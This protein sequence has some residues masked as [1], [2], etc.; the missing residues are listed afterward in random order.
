MRKE[1]K[2]TSDH[3]ARKF[4]IHQ[5]TVSSHLIR[6]K[7]PRKKDIEDRGQ[8]PPRRYEHEALGDM[9]HLDIKKLRYFNEEGVRDCNTG[10][11]N[12][13]ANKVAGSHCMHVAIDD[14]SHYASVSIM[15]DETAKRVSKLLEAV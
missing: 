10:N 15:E 13:S 3:I 8:E 4:K 9:I 2:L 7:L 1:G 6:A 11:R 12:T 5:R 14:Q